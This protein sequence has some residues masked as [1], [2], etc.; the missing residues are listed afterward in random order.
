VVEHV[1]ALPG[2]SVDITAL[3]LAS[4]LVQ[5]SVRVAMAV[6]QMFPK[7]RKPWVE[8]DCAGACTDL[9]DD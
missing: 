6:C 1:P 4:A 5:V 7:D 2:L 8:V 9:A 3:P